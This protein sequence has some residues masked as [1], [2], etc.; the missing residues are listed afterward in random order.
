[1]LSGSLDTFVLPDVLRFVAGGNLT[2][3]IEISRDEV[4][5]E[6]SIDQGRYVAASLVDEEAPT[7][8]DEALDVC[9]LLFDGTGGTF[10]V[11]EEDWV[12]GPLDLDAEELAVAVERRREEWAEV[13]S[14]LGS[15]ED[16][17]I[18]VAEL[19]DGTDQVTIN[20]EQWRLIALVDGSRSVQ[21]IARDAAQ[22]VYQA[23]LLL[24]ELAHVGM[25]TT[26]A[27]VSYRSEPTRAKPKRKKKKA[28]SRKAAD[29]DPAELLHELG[30]D[31]DGE[32]DDEDDIEDS[33]ADDE[34]T[35]DNTDEDDEDATV[36]PL[37]PP[38]REEQRL[39]LRR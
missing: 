27:G 37:R 33:A 23:A 6:L 26:G 24:A 22:S 14:V 20:A 4:G 29:P 1:M 17:V 5:G 18:L 31:E 35:D 39:R 7:T 9:V 8:V 38:T 21:D 28:S 25:V 19:P 30:G 16:P 15:L 34:D 3:R 32:D 12:G 11:I 2:G 10:Q 13:V 36:R